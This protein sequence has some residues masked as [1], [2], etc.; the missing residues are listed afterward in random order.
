MEAGLAVS[1][2]SLA[3]LRPLFKVI[4]QQLGWQSEAYFRPSVPLP[5]SGKATHGA[6]M[7][8]HKKGGHHGDSYHMSSLFS[9]TGDDRDDSNHGDDG[10]NHSVGTAS[11]TK[12]VT[13]SGG[14]IMKTSAF[15]VKVEEL[16]SE[17]AAERGTGTANASHQN[18]G[19]WEGQPGHGRPEEPG[20][21]V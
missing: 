8:S 16:G 17:S 11:T 14:G 4:V 3:C 12:L 18:S 21:M 10:D 7:G 5:E 20:H 19:P 13:A 1:A 9:R 6:T 15:T 2:G